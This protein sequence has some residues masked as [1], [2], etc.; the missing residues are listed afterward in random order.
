MTGFDPSMLDLFRQELETQSEELTAGLLRLE[1][2]PT[3]TGHVATLMRAAH[4]IKGAAR[5]VGFTDAVRLAHD[6]EDCFELLK[7][8]QVELVAADCDVLLAGVDLLRRYKEPSSPEDTE[9]VEA[10]AR[11]IEP[12]LS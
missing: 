9:A 7:S 5:I 6:L 3:E 11:E 4:S 8:G 2:A 1:Q 10:L 12:M